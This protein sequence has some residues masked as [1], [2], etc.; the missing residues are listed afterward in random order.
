[1]PNISG[2]ELADSIIALEPKTFIVFQTAYEEYALEA[3]KKGGI[4]YLVKPIE[5][6]AIKI[7]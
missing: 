2:F 6:E 1:M 5:S 4:G 3:F 7:S